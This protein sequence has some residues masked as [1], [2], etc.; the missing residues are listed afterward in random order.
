[1]KYEAWRGDIWICVVLNAWSGYVIVG[2]VWYGMVCH[3]TLVVDSSIAPIVTTEGTERY[4]SIS[5]MTPLAL[6]RN[7]DNYLQI[8]SSGNRTPH[9]TQRWCT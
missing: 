2:D 4:P 3:P 5:V 6:G 1:M 8:I 9:G 7:R